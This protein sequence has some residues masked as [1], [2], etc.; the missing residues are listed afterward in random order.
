MWR[1][2]MILNFSSH[3]ERRRWIFDGLS[4]ER[5]NGSQRE[6]VFAEAVHRQQFGII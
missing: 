5:L 2:C 3:T 4:G 1:S 6:L